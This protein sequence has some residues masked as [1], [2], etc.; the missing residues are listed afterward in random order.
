MEAASDWV[1]QGVWG[2]LSSALRV[3]REP[4]GLPTSIGGG[5]ALRL[6]PGPAYLRYRKMW[7]WIG[8]TAID[9]ALVIFWLVIAWRFPIA[10][11]LIAIPMLILIVLPDV[12]AYL[13]IHLGYDTTWYVITD[14]SMRLRSGV[15]TIHE[16]T[17]TFENVQN[18]EIVQGPIERRF[19]IATLKVETAGGVSHGQHGTPIGASNVG[20]LVGLEN[21]P[22]VREWIMQRV[23]ASRAAGLGDESHRPPAENAGFTAAHMRELLAIRASLLA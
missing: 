23:K 6:K 22:E 16:M 2:V 13:A 7:F 20:M 14:R 19:G 8:L 18:V 10:G 5:N 3:P 1:Y 17:L 15:W 21:A 12:I 9:I 11:V 4:P